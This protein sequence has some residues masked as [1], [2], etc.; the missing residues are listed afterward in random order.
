[1]EMFRFDIN[2]LSFIGVSFFLCSVVPFSLG[3]HCT[4]LQL[5]K[6][7]EVVGQIEM[8]YVL[9]LNS[10]ELRLTYGPSI[11]RLNSTCLSPSIRS[12]SGEN[13]LKILYRVGFVGSY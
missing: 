13:Y 5:P 6:L 3:G 1:M 7:G 11:S 8:I 10:F 9:F 2:S 12:F 4:G